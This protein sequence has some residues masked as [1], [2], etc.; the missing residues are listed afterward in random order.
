MKTYNIILKG[1]DVI[2]FPKKISR[3]AHALIKKL[4]RDNPTE[5]LGYAKNGIMDIK[6]H[7]WFQGFDWEGISNTTIVPPI[8]PKVSLRTC[9]GLGH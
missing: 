8:T 7:K 6:K 9:W 4:C 2:E 5:R 3:N 1:I